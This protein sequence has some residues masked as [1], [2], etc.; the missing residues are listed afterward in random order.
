MPLIRR[1]TGK[2]SI[3][4]LL[5]F[6][7]LTISIPVII[8]LL[9]YGYKQYQDVNREVSSQAQ[10][11]AHY[12]SLKHA[13]DLLHAKTL[14]ETLALYLD[15]THLDPTAVQGLFK[16]TIAANPQYA[17]L[18]MARPDGSLW[19]SSASADT[20]ANFS[21]R[22]SFQVALTEGRFAVAEANTS[23]TT[24]LPVLPFAAPVMD[25]GGQ[26]RAVLMLGLRIEE[27]GQYFANL[28]L[29]EGSRLAL[30]DDQG[31][32]LI[33]FPSLSTSPV[34]QPIFVWGHIV[35]SGKNADT[36]RTLDQTGRDITYAFIKLSPPSEDKHYLTVLVGLPTPGWFS[37]WWPVFGQTVFL[38]IAFTCLALAINAVLSRWIV[39]TGLLTLSRWAKAVGKGETA[40][41]AGKLTGCKEIVA[42]GAAFASMTESLARS[43]E[44]RD[45][46]EENLRAESVRLKT[47]LETAVDSVFVLDTEG[48]L[49]LHSP[50]FVRLLGSAPER[51][52][53]LTLDDFL[54]DPPP[55]AFIPKIP[56][57]LREPSTFEGAFRR[58]DGSVVDM[59][60]CAKGVELDNQQFL[61]IS[62]R[63]ITQRKKDEKLRDDVEQIIRHDIKSPLIGLY[64]IAQL[65]KTGKSA[66]VLTEFLPQI[67]SGV[68][69]AIN[70]LDAA[71]PLRKMEQG[72]YL[73]QEKPLNIARVLENAHDLLCLF[74][75]KR[76]VAIHVPP[77][78]GFS[79]TANLLLH[80]EEFLIEDMLMNL[81]RNAVEASQP[82]DAVT[83]RCHVQAATL[84]ISIHNTGTIPEAI[85]DTFFEKHVTSGKRHGTGLGTYSAQLIANAHGGHIE[86]TT[87]EA[88]GTTVTV[89]LPCLA[90][91]A[92]SHVAAG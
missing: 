53:S 76:K 45:R 19:V 7:T 21:D 69:Q 36:F 63:D 49:R 27:Y 41:D 70:I 20:S 3:K 88:E 13:D 55:S 73:P 74:A 72:E 12:F 92:G 38:V 2:Y 90:E 87:S 65:A 35:R 84:R 37:Q 46:A 18:T 59:E 91:P 85:R 66:M 40:I 17:Y 79:T 22:P 89:V 16:T 29:Q 52:A 60:A 47:L 62:A 42:L 51:A 68:R 1:L 6:S 75:T 33:R 32:R 23:R 48:S 30:L 10:E 31:T 67:E 25:Q 83:I 24:G 81:Y 44:A 5:A 54:I 80:G 77:E 64:N 56:A 86:F 43:Q 26:V 9:R 15:L 4:T 50:S 28:K 78:T 39:S 58:E 11:I 57:L 82:G 61:Y 71:E 34:G 14:L 8:L